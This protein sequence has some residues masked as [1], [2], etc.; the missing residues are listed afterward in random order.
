MV[1]LDDF[2]FILGLKKAK[3][4]LM[5][6]YLDG[7]MVANEICSYREFLMVNNINKG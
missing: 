5:L 4:T 3:V 6:S 2:D 7:I 1:N